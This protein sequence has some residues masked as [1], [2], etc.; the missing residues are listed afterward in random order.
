MHIEDLKRRKLEL[1]YSNEEIAQLTGVP[2]STVQ[3]IFAGITKHPRRDTLMALE[4][5]LRAPVHFRREDDDKF[6]PN[7][8]LEQLD[9][10]LYEME[11]PPTIHQ[12][13]I[14]P[15]MEQLRNQ[16]REYGITCTVCQTPLYVYLQKDDLVSPDIFV[17][18]DR[19]RFSARGLEGAPDLMIEIAD[20]STK[21]RDGGVKLYK[22]FDAG[23]REYWIIDPAEKVVMVYTLMNGYP[24]AEMYS[25]DAIV[26]VGIFDGKC[27]IDMAA[28]YGEVTFLDEL[29]DWVEK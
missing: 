18:C 12:L 17:V 8:R 1:G 25:F 11:T 15:L 7:A 4:A 24:F 16:S 28:A 20:L 3:K 19:N 27:K 13:M 26:P 10:Y 2:L 14:P 23:V 22:Y 5:L 9:G 6:S 21:K 29:E